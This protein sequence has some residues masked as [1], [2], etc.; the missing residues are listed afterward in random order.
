M[1]ATWLSIDRWAQII[2]MNPLHL[3]QLS[4][5]T[6]TPGNV[7][8][9][10]FF[11]ESWHNADRVGR[12]DVANAI[13][14]AELAISAEAGYNLL[15]DWTTEERMEYPRPA[16][17]GMLGYYGYNPSGFMKSVETRKGYVISGGIKTKNLLDDNV[18]VVRSD[19]DGDGYSETVTVTLA[20]TFTDTNR[21]HVYYSQTSGSEDWEIRPITVSISGGFATIKFYSW[22]IALRTAQLAMN[23]SALDA[24]DNASYETTVDVYEIY[25][26]PST[27]VQF[28]W[29]NSADL[30][31]CGSC[32]ACQFSTQAGCLH[33]REPRLGLAALSPASWDAASQSFT[34]LEW[35][36]C[37]EPDQVRLWYYSG[38]MD[39]QRARPY[40]ELAPE[41][42]FAIA[43]FACSFLERPI[44]GCSNVNQFI[45]K[46]RRDAAFVSQQEGGW[47]LTE[48]MLSNKLGTTM[49]ALAAYRILHQPGRRLT[50]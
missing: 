19:A 18:A 31:C 48:Q 17:P 42:E 32:A 3:H 45:E 25:N 37:R 5:P 11:L 43:H 2:G 27:Q 14:Q 39:N 20:V 40:V 9:D 41:W 15:P 28:M 23:P 13:K 7:C 16:N 36:A 8:G 34:M 1:T 22:Q 35:T 26:D 49:G 46:W 38:Y 24:D 12:N 50:K 47:R 30:N 21:I 44:C 6:L 4:S 29:E 10:I 33:L